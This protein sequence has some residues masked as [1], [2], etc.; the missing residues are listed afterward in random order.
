MLPLAESGPSVNARILPNGLVAA[1]GE[2]KVTPS[3]E[4]ESYASNWIILLSTHSPFSKKL[5]SLIAT[6]QSGLGA[7]IDAKLT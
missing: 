5:I 2:E 4:P 6:N 3:S 7:I 1:F